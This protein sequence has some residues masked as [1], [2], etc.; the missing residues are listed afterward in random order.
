MKIFRQIFGRKANNTLEN[1][2]EVAAPVA[3]KLYSMKE[4]Q[5]MVANI[6]RDAANLATQNTALREELKKANDL[7]TAAKRAGK[8]V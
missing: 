8:I 4:V 1:V 7:I 5:D 3:E 2:L 6:K